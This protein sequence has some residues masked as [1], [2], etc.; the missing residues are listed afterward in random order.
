MKIVKHET[1][2]IMW[3]TFAFDKYD[4]VKVWKHDTWME[5]F[6]LVDLI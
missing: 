3:S 5:R 2:K 1:R 6:H 4:S